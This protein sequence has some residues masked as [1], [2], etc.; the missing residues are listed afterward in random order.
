MD[1]CRQATSTPYVTID[2]V[3]IPDEDPYSYANFDFACNTVS[4]IPELLTEHIADYAMLRHKRVP[5]QTL[6]TAFTE[7]V[8]DSVRSGVVGATH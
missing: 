5:A 6:V 4:R 1:K 8:D 3:N 7:A 2:R